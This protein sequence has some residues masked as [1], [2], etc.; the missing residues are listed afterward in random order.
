MSNWPRGN[1]NYNQNGN[2]K[3]DFVWSFSE[4]WNSAL[5]VPRH[6]SAGQNWGVRAQS[7][8]GIRQLIFKQ[9]NRI[10]CDLR[11]A[12]KAFSDS[13][14]PLKQRVG[15]ILHLTFVRRTSRGPGAAWSFQTN[16]S[17]RKMCG[18]SLC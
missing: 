15:S 16:F 2:W 13:T 5:Q 18:V 6:S 10:M 14:F 4:Y 11:G 8:L 12:G 17:D 7:S 9:P 1:K 3:P